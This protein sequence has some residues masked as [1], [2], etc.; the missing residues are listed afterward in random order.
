MQSNMVHN[1]ASVHL[2][3]IARVSE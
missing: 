1:G 2:S 3:C